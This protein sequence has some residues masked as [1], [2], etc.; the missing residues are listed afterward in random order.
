MKKKETLKNRNKIADK[1]RAG[2]PIV[3]SCSGCSN[4][5]Q[6]ANDI[7]VKMHREKLAEMS[8][9]AGVGGG[10]KSLI[11]KAKAGRPILV[12]DGCHLQCAKEC[13]SGIDIKPAKHIILTENKFKKDDNAEIGLGNA[14][15]IY[16]QMVNEINTLMITHKPN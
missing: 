1:N 14:T 10:V 9:I 11:N 8:C 6:L 5:A 2:L 7:A 12:I 3:Y 15:E 16:E 4:V 13:L